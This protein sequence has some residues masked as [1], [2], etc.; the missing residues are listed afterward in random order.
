MG[1]KRSLGVAKNTKI[2]KCNTMN[3]LHVVIATNLHASL[4]HGSTISAEHIDK[5]TQKICTVIYSDTLHDQRAIEAEMED[6]ICYCIQDNDAR[7]NNVINK[8]SFLYLIYDLRRYMEI[9]ILEADV[10]EISDIL[11]EE[12]A[13]HDAV[14]EGEGEEALLEP[15]DVIP[16]GG[17]TITD[18]E[19]I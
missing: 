16:P 10:T 3:L 6:F 19:M 1:F 8:D 9:N 2:T 4:S 12:P 5:I 15:T 11:N 14:E 18:A 17:P 13:S 7:M